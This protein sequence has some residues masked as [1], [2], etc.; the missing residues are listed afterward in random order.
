[1]IQVALQR[2]Q[3][4]EVIQ[5]KDYPLEYLKPFIDKPTFGFSLEITP[6][7]EPVKGRQVFDSGLMIHFIFPPTSKPFFLTPNKKT[8][9]Y[10]QDMVSNPELLPGFVG[11]VISEGEGKYL[12]EVKSWTAGDPCGGG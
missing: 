1:M 10:L 4:G 9:I 2:P 3:N 8:P 7:L 6:A 12:L 5:I 11:K